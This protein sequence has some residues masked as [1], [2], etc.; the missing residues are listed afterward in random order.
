MGITQRKQGSPGGGPNWRHAG[1]GGLGIVLGGFFL[2][3]AVRNINPGDVETALRRMD[4]LWLMTGIAVYLISI[5]LRCLR[6]GLLLRATGSVK[7]RHAAEALITGFAANYVLPGRIGELFRA[8][9]ARRVFNMSRFTS[10]GT[11]VVERVCDGIVLVCALWI[12]TAWLLY[13]RF[14][15]AE[16]SWI[17]GIGSASGVV[18]GAALMFI[19]VSQRIDLRRLGVIESIAARWDRLVIGISSVLRGNA[20]IIALCSIGVWTLE[21]VALGSIVR[22]FGA[23]LSLT[24]TLTLLG[25]ASLSTLVPTAPG[26]LGTYQLVFA[27]VFEMFG[28][29]QTTGILAATA[30]QIFCFGT[31]TVLGGLVLLSRSGLT[32]WRAHKWSIPEGL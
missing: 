3:L 5:G 20:A 25:L 30:V 26:Y 29:P 23:S 1:L 2:W 19:L 32:A 8:D 17:F 14:L 13:T 6:W 31:V 28:Y 24:E 22:S 15:P 12:S 27:H 7:W 18:F 21:A 10:L 11:I 9:Y 4:R 16:A